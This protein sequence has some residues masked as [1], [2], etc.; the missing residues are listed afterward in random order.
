[1]P[2]SFIAVWD[3]PYS[4]WSVGYVDDDGLSPARWGFRDVSSARDYVGRLA[5]YAEVVDFTEA[6]CATE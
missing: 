5:R 2:D 1:M 3:S 4:G 6:A